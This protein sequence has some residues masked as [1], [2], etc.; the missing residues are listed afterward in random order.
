MGGKKQDFH[1]QTSKLTE[2]HQMLAVQMNSLGVAEF[3]RSVRTV[4]VTAKCFQACPHFRDVSQQLSLC[5][6][7][8]ITGLSQNAVNK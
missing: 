3:N 8:T 6:L 7:F 1:M 4:L 2:I 5:V